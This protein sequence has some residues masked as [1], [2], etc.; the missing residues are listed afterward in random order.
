MAFRSIVSASLV[1]N[2]SAGA[3]NIINEAV[4]ISTPCNCHNYRCIIVYSEVFSWECMA[5][6]SAYGRDL[7]G[8][9]R[10]LFVSNSERR[11]KNIHFVFFRILLLL[12]NVK[13]LTIKKY[14]ARSF[15]YTLLLIGFPSAVGRYFLYLSSCSFFH[16][17]DIQIRELDFLEILSVLLN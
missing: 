13:N 17:M 15:Y 9:F 4:S 11:S 3:I 12:F 16:R 8:I 5:E 2:V 1:V 7:V 6:K 14:L 10:K